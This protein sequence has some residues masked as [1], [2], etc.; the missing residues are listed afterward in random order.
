MAA[1]RINFQ[2]PGRFLL[3]SLTRLPANRSTGHPDDQNQIAL[4]TRVLVVSGVAGVLITLFLPMFELGSWQVWRSSFFLI[5]LLGTLA[6]GICYLILWAGYLR[7]ATWATT[8]LSGGLLLA[9]FYR[10]YAEWPDIHIFVMLP[11]VVASIFFTGFE[12]LIYLALY[13]LALLPAL[14]S[15]PLP[16][17]RSTIGFEA[18]LLAAVLLVVARRH[19]VRL[20]QSRSAA[21]AASEARLRAVTN[22]VSDIIAQADA[23]LRLRFISPSFER[24]TGWPIAAVLGRDVRDLFSLCHPDDYDLVQ[25]SVESAIAERHPASFHY[26]VRRRDGSYLWLETVMSSSPGPDDGAPMLTFSSR[27]LSD[28]MQAQEMRAHDRLK[29][30]FLSM[31]AH[32]LRDPLLIINGYADLLADAT[33]PLER[34]D[35]FAVQVRR[36]AQ[37]LSRIVDDL[38]DIERMKAQGGLALQIAPLDLGSLAADEVA[39]FTEFA[40]DHRFVLSQE[41]ALPLVLADGQRV[42]QVLRNLISNAVKY[43]PAGSTVQV[44]VRAN[45]GQAEL[46]VCDE[47]VGLSP[48]QQA[49]LF[50]PFY[51]TEDSSGVRG[52]GLGLSISRTIAALHGGGI[53]VESELGR[54]SCFVFW[55]PLPAEC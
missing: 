29:D 5:D 3:R 22:A 35:S 8:A 36:H 30:E 48:Q 17:E 40:P 42:A 4:L 39:A 18:V 25:R 10:Y 47:G 55:L 50:E 7:A 49:R 21:L 44:V 54:G 9:I 41:S 32:E 27:D 52:S 37:Q 31:V 28:R 16:F 12:L 6:V 34:R 20:E 38:L 23:E 14:L 43:S 46:L 26:R 2:A 53:R 19:Y 1:L 13:C 24:L 15:T 33:V 11:L 51:R 45:D